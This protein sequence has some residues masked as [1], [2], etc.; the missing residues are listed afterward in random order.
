MRIL[1]TGYKG[2]ISAMAGPILCSVTYE[3]TGL[4]TDG[5]AEDDFSVSTKDNKHYARHHRN[6]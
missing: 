5:A 4:D 1:L 2:Y 6:H 3:V